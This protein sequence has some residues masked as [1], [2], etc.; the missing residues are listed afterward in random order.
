VEANRQTATIR[1]FLRIEA[2]M[3]K[4][5]IS[6]PSLPPIAWKLRGSRELVV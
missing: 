1:I 2:R 3:R 4:R 6:L 5:V